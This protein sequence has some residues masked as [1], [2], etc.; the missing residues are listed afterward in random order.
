MSDYLRKLLSPTIL[1]KEYL[2]FCL[3]LVEMDLER[4]TSFMVCLL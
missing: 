2:L 3:Q 4:A 1:V